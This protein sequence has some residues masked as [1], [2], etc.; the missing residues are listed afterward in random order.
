MP[1]S[2]YKYLPNYEGETFWTTGRKSTL[3]NVVEFKP[4]GR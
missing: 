1:E 4:S 3:R 2:K